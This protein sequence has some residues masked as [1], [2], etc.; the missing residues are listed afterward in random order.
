MYEL[1]FNSGAKVAII[2]TRAKEMEFILRTDE[3]I[4]NYEL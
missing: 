2:M 3:A 1:F 4:M